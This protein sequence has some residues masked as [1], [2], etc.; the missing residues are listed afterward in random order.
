MFGLIKDESGGKITAKF[1][2]LRPEL[3]KYLADDSCYNKER[4]RKIK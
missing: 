3:Y 4:V 2:G 1:V